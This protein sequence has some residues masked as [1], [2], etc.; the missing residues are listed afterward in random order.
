MQTYFQQAHALSFSNGVFEIGFAEEHLALVDNHRNHDM[1]AEQLAELG[2]PDVQF[3]FTSEAPPVGSEAPPPLEPTDERTA[4]VEGLKK[5]SDK[6]TPQPEKI[7]PEAFK[8]DPLIQKALELF[9]GRI[10]EV[11]Q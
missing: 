9:R 6:T 11:R 10:V 1:L 3:R 4:V 7:D 8:D 5:G 2:Y